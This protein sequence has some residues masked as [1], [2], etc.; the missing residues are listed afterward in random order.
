MCGAL[1]LWPDP[2]ARRAESIHLAAAKAAEEPGAEV[3]ATRV[4]GRATGPHG[5][6]ATMLG[7]RPG[8]RPDR[9]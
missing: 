8:T 3:I 5:R 6:W 2:R 9:A 4:G 1:E 7:R